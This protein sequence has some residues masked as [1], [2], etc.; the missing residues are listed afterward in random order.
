MRPSPTPST[1]SLLP[2]TKRSAS[3]N[4]NYADDSDED[5]LEEEDEKIKVV[6][7]KQ[8]KTKPAKRVKGGEDSPRV[9]DVTAS[10]SATLEER[11]RRNRLAA[12]QSRDRQKDHIRKLEDRVAELEAEL[13]LSKAK[14][15]ACRC[16]SRRRH[17]PSPYPPAQSISRSNSPDPPPLPPQSSPRVAASPHT[18]IVVEQPPLPPTQEPTTGIGSAMAALRNLLGVSH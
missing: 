9:V 6:T 14:K 4:P 8:V 17:S 11:K 18:P 15:V 2:P 12:Q 3:S 1:S 16:S 5:V 7:V 13:K 10:R